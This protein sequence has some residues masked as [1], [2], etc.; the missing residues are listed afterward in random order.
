MSL[1]IKNPDVE[2]AARELARMRGAGLTEAVGSAIQLALEAE[3]AKPRRR[4]T[5]EDMLSATA[6]FRKSTGLDQGELGVIR[7]DFDALWDLDPQSR[8]S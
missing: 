1:F 3:R 6:R 2:R 7:E 5:L 8:S 4:P